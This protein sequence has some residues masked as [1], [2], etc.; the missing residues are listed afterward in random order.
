MKPEILVIDDEESLRYTFSCFLSR[1]GYNVTA[2]ENYDEG[3]EKILKNPPHII[4]SDIVLDDKTGIDLLREIKEKGYGC[5]VIMVTG[6]PSL[7]TASEAVRLGAFDYI[8]KPVEKETLL[9][10]ARRALEYKRVIDENENYR[11]N[12]EAIF[13]SV[14]DGIITVD[15]ELNIIEVNDAA[16]K[17]FAISADA[18]GKPFHLRL[19]D[20]AEQKCLKALEL[21]ISTRKSVELKRLECHLKGSSAK[22][23]S[24]NITPLI[25]KGKEFCGAVMVIRDETV[26][27]EME[28]KLQQRENYHNIVGKSPAMTKIYSLL[29]KLSS[30]PT[31]VLI[32]G[33]SGTGKELIAEA[34]HYKGDRKDKPFIK[35]NCSALP[36]NLLESEL[37]GHVKGAFTGAIKDKKGRFLLADKGTIF[38]DEIGDITPALQLRLL[39]VLQEK[40]FEQVGDSRSVKVDVRIIAATNQSL[41]EKVKSGEFREDLYYRLKV[42]EINLP[43]LKERRADILLLIEHF[44]EEFNKK[45]NKNIKSLSRDVQKIF[46]T[47]PWPGNVREFEH[48]LEHA[49]IL[50]NQNIIT[51]DDLPVE[52]KLFD[53]TSIVRAPSEPLSGPSNNYVNEEEKLIIETLKKTRWNK[54]KAAKLLNMDRS[55]LYRKINKYNIS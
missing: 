17:T 50:C 6:Y 4:F 23:V 33:E 16:T 40:E 12:L 55:T 2:A 24:L 34:L 52:L 53:E 3:I 18:V 42:V 32:T 41:L 26:I 46:M 44:I 27:V 47:Y 21:T 30:V 22:V 14:K 43:A 51:I 37:F 11:S 1:E 54:A 31:T 39:R 38:L 28:N 35:V 29:E 49:F 13:S 8:A 15:K 20:C 19:K 10:T 48:A 25:K 36:E 45:F 5:P 9:H 7:E